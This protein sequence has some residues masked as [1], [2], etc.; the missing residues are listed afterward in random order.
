MNLSKTD[1]YAVIVAGGVGARMGANKP[2]QFLPLLGKPILAHTLEKFHQ[3]DKDIKLIV[4]LPDASLYIWQ[5]YIETSGFAIPHEVTIGGKSR[6]ESVCKGLILV[7][8][9][10]TVAIHDAV[11][12]CLPL[13][14]IKRA[15][16]EAEDKHSAI[17]VIPAKDSLRQRNRSGLYQAVNRQ[18]FVM[19]Q[20]PQVFNASKL[21]DAYEKFQL[22]DATDDA[23]VWELAGYPVNLIEGSDVNIKITTPVDLLLAEVVFKS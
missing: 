15:F 13:E 9:K 7:P 23:T 14:L 16:A 12:P 21:I 18:D 8:H 6:T 11:R 2:K 10:G 22:P 19:V 1:R 4:V 3:A 5:E 17:P 20:T